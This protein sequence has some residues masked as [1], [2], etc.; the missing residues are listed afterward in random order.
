MVCN[1][2]TIEERIPKT[3]LY[4]KVK[5]KRPRGRPGTCQIE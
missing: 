5:R 3:M 1:A 2:I 4:T